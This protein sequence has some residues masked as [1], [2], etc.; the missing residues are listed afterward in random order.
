MC[1]NVPALFAYITLFPGDKT[2]KREQKR[3]GRKNN[4]ISV[5]TN[6]KLIAT[7]SFAKGNIPM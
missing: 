6:E 1:Y 3:R 4:V 7:F 2:L 5:K